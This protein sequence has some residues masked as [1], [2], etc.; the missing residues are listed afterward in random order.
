MEYLIMEVSNQAAQKSSTVED[1]DR[2]WVLLCQQ[3]EVEA[4]G[5]LVERHQQRMLNVAYRMIGNYE[6]A[7][8]AVQ[9]AFL[10]AFRA[11]RQFRGEARFSTW[12][13]GIVVNTAK[14][15]RQQ[16]NR[17]K[18]RFCSGGSCPGDPPNGE[19]GGWKGPAASV[20]GDSLLD[21]LEKKER[22]ALVQEGIAS[23]EGDQREILVLRDIQGLPY[24][25]IGVIL[26]LPPG[27]V[28]SRLFRARIALKETLLA[29]IGDW[30]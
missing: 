13:Y 18:A 17:V 30:P 24:E 10:A 1:D 9:E 12:L 27:T 4:F 7:C 5:V 21:G 26:Q 19:K 25:E 15:R 2:P 20:P 3:G 6:D 16:M 11:I 8:D 22:E 23:L 14:T 29:R 28:R